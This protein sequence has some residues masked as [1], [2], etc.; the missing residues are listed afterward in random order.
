MP[1]LHASNIVARS[2]A[3]N[4]AHQSDMPRALPLA[5]TSAPHGTTSA[6]CH[7]PH[8]TTTLG[9]FY[10][11]FL[12][13]PGK[14]SSLQ[15]QKS[16]EPGRAGVEVEG[17]APVGVGAC[18]WGWGLYTIYRAAIHYNIGICILDVL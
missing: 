6:R 1:K 4:H 12:A 18:Q 9:V 10:R 2:P 16:V 13:F 3:T 14:G 7:L 5:R 11:V 8:T 17:G 15:H